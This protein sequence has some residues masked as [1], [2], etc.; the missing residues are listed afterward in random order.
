MTEKFIGGEDRTPIHE[1]DEQ[2]RVTWK[3][4]ERQP[5]TEK[6]IQSA[7]VEDLLAWVNGFNKNERGV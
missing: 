6:D 4:Y 5:V 7:S 2:A 3:E 1:P